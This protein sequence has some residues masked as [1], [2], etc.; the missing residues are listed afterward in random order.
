MEYVEIEDAR[1]RRGLR[2]V[3]TAGGPGPW[4]EAA[5]GIFHVKHLAF[6]PVR[7]AAGERNEAL[8]AWTGQSSAPVAVW[9]DEPPCTTS[10]AILWLAERL[11]P[12]PPLVPSDAEERALCLGICD[13]IH[14]E[15]GLGWSRRLMMFEPILRASTDDAST[16]PLRFMA[17]K[18]GYSDEAAARAERRIVEILGFLSMRLSAQRR[19]GRRALVG[20]RLSAA[21][22]YWA[23]F[24]AMLAPLPAELCPMPD[25]LRALYT[26]STGPIAEALD[27]ALLEH[28][29]F[30]Y[31]EHLSLPLDF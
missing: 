3:L 11:A 25:G 9:E 20:E 4:S 18:Y 13:E 30:V 22:V 26:V 10:R 1:E 2:L 17:W 16:S 19:V 24:A 29:D 7:Q 12:E 14:G 6:T 27:P 31:R 21:D 8:Q 28:R 5:K 23:T 15:N